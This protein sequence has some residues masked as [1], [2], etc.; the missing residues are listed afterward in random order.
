MHTALW[1]SKCTVNSFLDVLNCL[2]NILYV[3]YDVLQVIICKIRLWWKDT[4]MELPT[5][6]EQHENYV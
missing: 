1:R 4:L 5:G 2:E 3:V 6:C